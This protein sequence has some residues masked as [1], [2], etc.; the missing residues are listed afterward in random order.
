MKKHAQ[1]A[2]SLF[3]TRYIIHHFLQLVREEVNAR[4]TCFSQYLQNSILRNN[5]WRK[6][7]RQG[8][9]IMEMR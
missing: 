4:E 1:V 5:V 8:R 7:E 9:N 6:E 2:I 3:C